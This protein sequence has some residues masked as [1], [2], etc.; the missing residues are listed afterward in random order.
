MKTPSFF[1]NQNKYQFEL[2]VLAKAISIGRTNDT[3]YEGDFVYV[4]NENRF[5]I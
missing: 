3:A 4:L 1:S 2:C 5:S